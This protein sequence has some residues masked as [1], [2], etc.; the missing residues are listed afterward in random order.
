MERV[1]DKPA[2]TRKHGACDECRTPQPHADVIRHN[3]ITIGHRSEESEVLGG[4]EW[5]H[6]LPLARH[7]MSLLQPED[8]GSAKKETK[9]KQ[10]D[11]PA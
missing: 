1:N 6:S 5:L 8:H 4:R 11:N 7:P 9:G 10:S 3:E 2:P